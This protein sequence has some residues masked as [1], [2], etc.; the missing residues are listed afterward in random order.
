MLDNAI[1][2]DSSP[3]VSSLVLLFNWLCFNVSDANSN[4]CRRSVSLTLLSDVFNCFTG[5]Y[6]R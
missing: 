2:F 3:T 5:K 1:N 4:I 6:S